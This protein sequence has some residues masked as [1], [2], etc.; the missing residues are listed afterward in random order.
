M[1]HGLRTPAETRSTAS[2]TDS[3]GR[4]LAAARA[5]AGAQNAR[6]REVSG[7]ASDTLTVRLRERR[8][9]HARRSRLY[10][11]VFAGAG[12]AVLAAGVAMLVLPGPGVLVTATGLGMLALEFR[13]AERL[14]LRAGRQARAACERLARRRDR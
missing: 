13:W 8:V 1:E 5:P 3:P 4:A 7:R 11:I 12:F 6:A 14:L 9:R 10:R 2:G